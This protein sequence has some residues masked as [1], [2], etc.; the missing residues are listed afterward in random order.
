MKLSA[1]LASHSSTKCIRQGKARTVL[2]GE[3]GRI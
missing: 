3:V 1:R 2:H